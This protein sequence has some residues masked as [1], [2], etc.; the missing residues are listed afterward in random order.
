[1]ALAPTFRLLVAPSPASVLVLRSPS[2]FST[3]RKSVAAGDCSDEASLG[4]SDAHELTNQMLARDIIFEAGPLRATRVL[5]RR[6]VEGGCRSMGTACHPHL[7]HAPPTCLR[8]HS[9]APQVVCNA[10]L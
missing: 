9:R 4:C 5:K 8:H 10:L 6:R 3:I 7:A 1:M 2:K